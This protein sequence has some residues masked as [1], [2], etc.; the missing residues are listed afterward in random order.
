MCCR[1]RES[2]L[3]GLAYDAPASAARRCID[4]GGLHRIRPREQCQCRVG[5]LAASLDI[6][7]VGVTV[8]AASPRIGLFQEIDLAGKS[9]LDLTNVG[10]ERNV[11]CPAKPASRLPE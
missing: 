3:S 8:F 7:V 4:L 6:R 2:L 5:A 11:R 9:E 1:R 10:V